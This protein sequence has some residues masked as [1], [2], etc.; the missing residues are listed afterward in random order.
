[1]PA[2]DRRSGERTDNAM[3]H[4][5]QEAFLSEL[6]RRGARSIRRVV[7]RQNRTRL[8]S[9]S[10]D[11]TTLNAHACF[12]AAPPRI[13]D[14]VAR[15][16]TADPR[17][18]SHR[19]A[20]QELRT[21][22]GAEAGLRAARARPSRRPP[23][24]TECCASPAQRAFLRELYARLNRSRFGGQLPKDLAIRVSGRMARRL[25]QVRFD[26]ADASTGAGSGDARQPPARRQAAI[27]GAA[28]REARPAA[29]R[30]SLELSL[31]ADL[32]ME[33]NERELVDTLLHEMAH[34]EA[35][36]ST[37]HRGHGKP[38]KEVAD[39][40]GCEAR[41][42]SRH[43]INRRGRHGALPRRVPR[44]PPSWAA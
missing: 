32:F 4:H 26:V 15:F 3:A 11:R 28:G 38:W 19:R 31:N 17:T 43:R 2:A 42:C 22:P 30:R 24:P 40:V 36:L 25:G 14:A 29:A 8:L 44:I 20:V 21:W 5:T 23:R 37:G 12:L 39:R 10:R 34:V 1:M 41:A 16:V 6:K 7:F 13:M 35:Y 9:L 18:A 27:R 33:G